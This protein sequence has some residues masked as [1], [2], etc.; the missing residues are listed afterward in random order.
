MEQHLKQVESR[1]HGDSFNIFT[2]IV[3]PPVYCQSLLRLST[4]LLSIWS[5][6]SSGEIT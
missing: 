5:I 4:L 1:E 3:H 6:L 2:C